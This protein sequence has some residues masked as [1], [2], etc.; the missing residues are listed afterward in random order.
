MA[1]AGVKSA[2][3]EEEGNK[4]GYDS[5]WVTGTKINSLSIEHE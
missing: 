5:P 4:G 3:P 2:F 1:R